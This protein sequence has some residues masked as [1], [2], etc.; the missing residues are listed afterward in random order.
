MDGQAPSEPAQL[1][2]GQAIAAPALQTSGCPACAAAARTLAR[3]ALSGYIYAVGRI[4]PRFPRPSVEK[5]LAQVMR[6]SDTRN[7]TDAQALRRAVVGLASS[8]GNFSY[9]VNCP[10]YSCVPVTNVI[11]LSEDDGLTC[12]KSKYSEECT[13]TEGSC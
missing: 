4:A 1:T 10:G 9:A 8:G 3:P 5:E 6:A 13:V 12:V 2:A 11:A 7:L